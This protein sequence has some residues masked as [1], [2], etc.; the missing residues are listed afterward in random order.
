MS[1]FRTGAIDVLVCT[2]VVEVGV[3]VP[4]ASV[5]MVSHA[6][7]F[8]LSQLHQLRG[9]VGRSG[10]E[11]YCILLAE[12]AESLTPQARERL[13]VMARSTDGFEIAEM[14]LK[15]R[16]PGQ[17]FG[18]RQAGFPEFRFADL[19]RDADLI[20]ETRRVARGMLET[21]PALEALEHRTLRARV[22]A[23]ETVE[24]PVVEEA[25]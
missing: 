8:G 1:R 4:N 13:E 14:D 9:R 19:V 12:P 2:T 15:I 20:A 11:A 6:E 10:Q 5:M 17:V 16:G 22:D 7:R 18:T 25:G 21:D 3:D 24:T 23:L